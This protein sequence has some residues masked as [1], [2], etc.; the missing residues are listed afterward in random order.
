MPN[1]NELTPTLTLAK[2]LEQQENYSEAL[3]I[4]EQLDNAQADEFI[5]KKINYLQDLVK[6]ADRKTRDA[7]GSVVLSSV[8]RDVF[9]IKDK[10]FSTSSTSS[11]NDDVASA[12]RTPKQIS[13]IFGDR[14]SDMTI[15]QI[16]KSLTAVIGR[17]RKLKNITIAEFI[18]A[19][20]KL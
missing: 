4:Y 7:I 15:E 3:R 10:K 18:N 9:H 16:S 11:Q 20:E 6:T 1:T 17:N 2:M 5:N 14:F 12:F 8:E 13:N 19:I